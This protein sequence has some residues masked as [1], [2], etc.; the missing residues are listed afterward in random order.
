M[1]ASTATEQLR[2]SYLPLR[3]VVAEA[4]AV[5][6]ELVADCRH[7]WPL[8]VVSILEYCLHSGCT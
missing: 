4:A 6:V 5:E 8:L 3:V 2:D 1:S 7:V